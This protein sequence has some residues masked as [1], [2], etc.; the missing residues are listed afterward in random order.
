LLDVAVG[1]PLALVGRARRAHPLALAPGATLVLYTDGLFERRDRSLDERLAELV[2]AVAGGPADVEG[3]LD[4]LLE[5][6]L[7]PAPSRDDTALVAIR[8]PPA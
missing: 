5:R 6:M 3:L 7:G 8:R 4:H 2:R 1:P